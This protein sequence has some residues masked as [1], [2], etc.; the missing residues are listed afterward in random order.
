MSPARAL[1]E[2]AA[3][4]DAAQV[5]SQRAEVLA[6]RPEAPEDLASA[7]SFVHFRIGASEEYGIAY[8]FV[9]EVMQVP[10]I[11]RVPCAPP[12]IAGVINRRGEMLVV[13]DLRRFLHGGAELPAPGAIDVIVVQAAGLLVGVRVDALLGNASFRPGQLG[14]ALPSDGTRRRGYIEG[15]LHGRISL[16]DMQALLSDPALQAP[17]S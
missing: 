14:E 15:L 5:L 6:R 11:T 13:L 1:A 10:A 2:L 7:E 17:T 8:R 3:R 4:G 12:A 9:E 16:L